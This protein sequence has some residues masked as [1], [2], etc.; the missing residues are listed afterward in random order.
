MSDDLDRS[1]PPAPGPVR[2]FTFPRVDRSTLDNGLSVLAAP[3]GHLPVVTAALVLEGGAAGEASDKAGLAQLVASALDAGT[4]DRSADELAW[5]LESLGVEFEA[6]ARWDG[7]I[8]SVVAPR[9]KLEPAMA[10]FAEIVRQPA[11]RLEDVNRLRDE[12]L[13]DILQ[14]QK[15][16]RALAA[17]M[18]SRFVFHPSVPYARPLVGTAQTVRRL[19]PADLREFCETWYAPRGAALLMVGDINTAAAHDLA[20]RH[21]GDWSDHTSLLKS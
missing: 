14:R 8:L 17:D 19:T 9:E 6:D 18:F 15:E 2:P 5:A 7:V 16:P 20:P 13:A 21:F 12:Q 3:H 1:Q 11:F 10:L 4:H